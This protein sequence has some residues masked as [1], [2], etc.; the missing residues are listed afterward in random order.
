MYQDFYRDSVL[1]HLPLFALFLFLAVFVGT[2]VWLFL[3][4]RKSPRFRQLAHLPLDDRGDGP[5][6][7]RHE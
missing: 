7:H 5:L 3:F 4:Q 6:E 1:L 2:V